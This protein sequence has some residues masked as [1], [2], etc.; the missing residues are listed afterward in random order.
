MPLRILFLGGS[1]IISSASVRLA[2]ARGHEVTVL[3]RGRTTHRP[4]PDSVETLVA[5]QRDA[6]AVDA[7]LGDREFDVVAQFL[8]FTPEHVQT[9]LDRFRGRTGQ[10]VFISSA[11]AYQKPPASV[12]VTESTPLKNPFWQYSRDKIACEDLLMRAY[13]DDDLPMTIVRPSHTYDDSTLPTLGGWTDIARMRQGK[14]VIVHGDGT[15]QWTLTHT[16]DFAVGFVGLLGRPETV[17]NAYTITGDS[18]PTWDQVY[19]WLGRAAGAEP[20][21]VHVASETIARELPD[22]GPGLVGDKAHSMV[23]DTTKLRRIVPEFTTTIPYVEGARRT[24]AWFDAHE[25]AQQ[26]DDELDAAFDRLAERG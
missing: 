9:D 7:A 15:T 12:P 23:F 21:L 4:L 6:A 11:S 14:P 3:N 19:T 8:A 17:G 22:K 18:A 1:G 2:A 20:T 25:D 5:D 13:R 10:Y 16:D 24:L 26:V